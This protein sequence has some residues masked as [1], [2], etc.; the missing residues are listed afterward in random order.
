MKI[1]NQCSDWIKRSK[2]KDKIDLKRSFT[3]I[4]DTLHLGFDHSI[5]CK[6]VTN[7]IPETIILAGNGAVDVKGEGSCWGTLENKMKS[8]GLLGPKAYQNPLDA[9]T[10]L[11][12]HNDF[13]KSTIN[14][15]EPLKKIASIKERII[16]TLLECD[17]LPR[18]IF[19][20]SCDKKF[21]LPNS[22]K[23]LILT[24]NW[25]L[26]LFK[27]FK[28]VIQVHGRCDYPEQAILPLQNISLLMAQ[29]VGDIEKLN[30]GILPGPFLQKVLQ[31]AKK[32]IF[33][34][35]GLNEY[36]AAL[37]HF[38][39]GFLRTNQHIQLGIAARNDEESYKEAK[40]R[41]TRFFSPM[42]IHD[43]LC[44]MIPF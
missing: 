24:T 37:W 26:G 31:G 30:C 15:E 23:V 36:D 43:C 22:E 34:G 2:Y 1:C 25:D 13:L 5:V 8:E 33:W 20:T 28:N 9:L 19:C 16:Q 21:K 6:T 29:T 10:W 11:V 14:N 4:A 18:E 35:T 40:K 7:Y 44:Q 17:T 27:K 32:F 3:K 12:A 39:G 42:P 41:V 38:L